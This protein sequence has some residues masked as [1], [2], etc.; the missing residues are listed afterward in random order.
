MSRNYPNKD[1]KILWG[2]AAAR[3]AFPDCRL[4]CI[5]EPEGND[6]TATFGKMA[7]I[8][9]HKDTGPRGDPLFP[10]EDRDKYEN[11]ILL[12]PTHHD[13][14]DAKPYKYDVA[15]LRDW[16]GK[17]EEWVRK[18]LASEMPGVTFAELEIVT[19]AMLSGPC[20]PV[21][22]FAILN[23]TEKMKRNGLT[24]RIHFTLTMGLAKAREVASFVEH[25]AVMDNEFP[26]RLKAGFVEE[27][28]RLLEDG[29]SGDA[30]FESLRVFA[31]NGSADFRQQAAALAVLC[32]LFETCEVFE[33]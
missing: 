27:Y 19:R 21:T 6:Q 9:A 13:I 24:D 1:V 18:S 29:T 28:R 20:K 5:L 11:L 17:H 14:V 32:Y 26:E 15:T 25:V 10:D 16:K 4:E 2:L 22:D 30:L 33:S 3:C 7:H 8:V 31:S 12:C 23:P